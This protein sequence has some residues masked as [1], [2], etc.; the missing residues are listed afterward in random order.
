[1]NIIEKEFFVIV[2]KFLNQAK[3]SYLSFEGGNEFLKIFLKNNK[4]ELFFFSAPAFFESPFNVCCLIPPEFDKRLLQEPRNFEI[5]S[6]LKSCKFIW[7]QK[8]KILQTQ[9]TLLVPDIMRSL[10]N[11]QLRTLPLQVNC[12]ITAFSKKLLFSKALVTLT[13]KNIILYSDTEKKGLIVANTHAIIGLGVEPTFSFFAP[14]S[15]VT[16]LSCFRNQNVILNFYKNQLLQTCSFFSLTFQSKM[17]NSSFFITQN[18]SLYH[19]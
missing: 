15:I 13:L 8:E 6:D 9:T 18:V 5:R 1:M 10:K 2:K 11:F 16:F 19:L 3:S 12:T 17:T 14:F 4:Q 7:K